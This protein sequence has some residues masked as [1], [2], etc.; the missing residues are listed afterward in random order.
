MFPDLATVD[1]RTASATLVG[2]GCTR[3]DLIAPV[4]VRVWI[5]EMA[6]GA[7]WPYVDYH[8]EAGEVVFIVEGELIEGER[9]FDAGTYLVFGPHSCHQPRTDTGA[10]LFGFNLLRQT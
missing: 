9:R 5:V 4:G 1:T 7:R 10:R 6:P 8:N 2:P 3:R